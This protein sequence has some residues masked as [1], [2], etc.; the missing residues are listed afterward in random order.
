MAIVTLQINNTINVSC[1]I[2]DTAY[3]VPTTIDGGFDI[4]SSGVVEIGPIT[5]ITPTSITCTTTIPAP[6]NGSFIFFSKDNKAN[7]SSLLGYYA[8]V[9]IRNNSLDAHAEMYQIGADY[10]ESSK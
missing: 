2:G 4:N 5:N 1:Q 7:L 8:E 6:P 9:D 3:Y 10:F